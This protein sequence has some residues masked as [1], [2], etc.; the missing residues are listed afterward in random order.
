MSKYALISC[1]KLKKE[2]PCTAKEMYLESQLFKKAVQYISKQN[3]DDWFILSAKYGL[4]HKDT[5]IEPYDITLNNMNA[6]QRKEWS[7][8][9]FEQLIKLEAHKFDFYAGKKY[10]EY[11]IPLLENRGIPCYIPLEGKGIGEQLKFYKD[12]LV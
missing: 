11:L 9:V 12:Q 10:R 5:L 4:L 6:L 7:N 3:Y 2:Y 8:E 1:T